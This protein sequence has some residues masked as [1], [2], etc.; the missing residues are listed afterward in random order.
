MLRLVPPHREMLP[1][2]AE[3]L[4]RDW[5]PNTM[6][7]VAPDQLA[8]Y[9]A[10]PDDFL[11]GLTDP[12]GTVVLADGRVVPRLPARLFWLDDGDFCGMINLRWQTGTAEL[13]PYCLGHIG[14]SVV[15]WKQRRGYA[16]RALGAVLPVAREVGLPH[17]ELSCDRDNRASQ[18]VIEAN[19]GELVGEFPPGEGSPHPYRLYRIAL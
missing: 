13:P 17:V 1:R 4:A 2:Y 3:A 12:S 19:G 7:N 9:R 16:T 6:R 14:Y 11:T 15:P 5:S 10:N 8:R 18:R